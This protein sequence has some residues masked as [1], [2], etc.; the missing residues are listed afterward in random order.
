[1]NKQEF[2]ELKDEFAV[3]IY[4][5]EKF[6]KDCILLDYRYNTR[7]YDLLTKVR[8]YEVENT[9]LARCIQAHVENHDPEVEKIIDDF[10]NGYQKELSNSVMKHKIAKTVTEHNLKLNPDDIKQFETEYVDF[11]KAHHPVV[12]AL[13]SKEEQEVY[14]KL[15]VY[16]YENNIAGFKKALEEASSVF[17][18]PDYPDDIFTKV[19]EYY[20][21]IRKRI[22]QDFTK[23]QTVYPFVKRTVFAD[24]MSE[25]YEEG[26]LKT[27]LNKLMSD[28][29]KLH[30][31]VVKAFNYDIKLVE[32]Q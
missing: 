24:E 22:G 8:F 18:N 7:Y 6:I 21:D 2:Q 1:M 32:E 13:A 27:N 14:E 3:I 4:N 28:N 15:K 20:Y 16:Y 9:L 30:A 26:E 11:I 10:H 23:K 31:D 17:Q 5:Y 25:A 29:K 19:S 12:N